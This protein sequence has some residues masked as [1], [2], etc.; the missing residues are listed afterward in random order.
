M[1]D[2][3]KPFMSIIDP[4]RPEFFN[5][6][7]MPEA[8]REFCRT[9]NQPTPHNTAQFVRTILESLSLSYRYTLEKL[10]EISHKD[11]ER[12]HIVGGGAQNN[13][14][15]QLTADATGLPVQAGPVEATAIGNILVQAMAFGRVSCLEE[16]RDIVKRSFGSKSFEPKRISDWQGVY[17][18][19]IELK[20]M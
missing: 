17:K 18:R 15:C 4:D 7:D 12:I 16:L 20:Q 11:I 8:I 19:F 14:L 10:Q 2:R 5:P 6:P 3:A 1:A 13:L 9:T